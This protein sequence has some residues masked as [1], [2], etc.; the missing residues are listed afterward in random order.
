MGVR[1]R[2]HTQRCTTEALPASEVD[3]GSGR[4]KLI[5]IGAKLVSHGRYVMFQI[6]A[7]AVSR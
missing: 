5:K 6:G 7:G 3:N 1:A 4:R 2:Q